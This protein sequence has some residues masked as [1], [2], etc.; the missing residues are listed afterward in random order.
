MIKI[1]IEKFPAY[2][3]ITSHISAFENLKIQKNRVYVD[4]FTNDLQKFYDRR[5]ENFRQ[6]G[7]LKELG[8]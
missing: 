4:N 8:L 1:F 5:I 6:R 7:I 2:I 3:E